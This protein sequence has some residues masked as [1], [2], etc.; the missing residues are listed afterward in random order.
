MKKILLVFGFCMFTLT[1]FS[2]EVGIRFGDAL[3]GNVALDAVFG[4]GS[5]RIHADLAFGNGV[6]LEVLWDVIYD[7]LGTSPLNW[8]LGV[9]PSA[10]IRD[11]YFGLGVAGELGLE[12]V[13]EGAPITIG[14]DWRPVF[15]LIEDTDFRADSFGLNVRYRFGG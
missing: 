4:T 5:S 11:N 15:V 12:W 14:A 7:Q 13:I 1:G 3:G 6:G 2:Q 9:G 10:L 8:Y